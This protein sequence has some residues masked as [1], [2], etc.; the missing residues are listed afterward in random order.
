MP[1]AAFLR[2]DSE[3]AGWG[4]WGERE[5]GKRGRREREGERE[6][7]GEEEKERV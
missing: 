3:A 2:R 5:G 4:S 6:E 7:E 1:K